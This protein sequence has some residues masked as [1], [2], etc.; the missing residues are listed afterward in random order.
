MQ[1]CRFCLL[2]R[3]VTAVVLSPILPAV[4]AAIF[5]FTALSEAE[6]WFYQQ[7]AFQKRFNYSTSKIRNLRSEKFEEIK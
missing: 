6:N 1:L 3:A 4:T 5:S 7:N 2:D